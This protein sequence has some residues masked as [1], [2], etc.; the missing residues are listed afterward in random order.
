M[1]HD[2]TLY[3]SQEHLDI[4]LN[5]TKLGFWELELENPRMIC[6]PQCKINIGAG[7]KPTVS[8]ED[9]IN[10]IIPEDREKMQADVALA[11]L[12]GGGTYNS[13]YR[14]IH[15][16]GSLHWIEANG[17]VLYQN[18]KPYRMV[19][20]TLDITAKKDMEMLK[21][22]LL[23][24]TT[25]EL[26]TP[27]TVIRG[28]LQILYTFIEKT[29]NTRFADISKKSL[30]ATERMTR[31]LKEI[32]D[33][34]YRKGDQIILQKQQFDVCTLLADTIA[35]I[36][37]VSPQTQFRLHASNSALVMADRDR[38]GQVL[39]NLLNNAI[40]FAPDSSEIV[41]VVDQ[42][43]DQIKISIRDRGIGLSENEYAKIFQKYYRSDQIK[44]KVEG[45]G[46]GLYLS[47][48]IITRHGGRIWVEQPEDK[49]GSKFIFTL[50]KV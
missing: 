43:E 16:D 31:L 20:T 26:K 29:G 21:D 30:D 28:Y 39:I 14:V 24:F 44:S 49:I 34:E 35:S 11:L 1:G 42:F 22:E 5:H 47:S 23:S 19:G 27:V 6:T 50:P 13:Q 40:K 2:Q 9:L 25:H 17:K 3:V 18:E 38:I 32:A 4:A 33:P 15:P 48:E 7:E 12:P 37:M 8:Y 10:A 36:N 45:S 46:I 41:M